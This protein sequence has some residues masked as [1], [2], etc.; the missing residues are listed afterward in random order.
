MVTPAYLAD[1]RSQ[2]GSRL[3]A[4]EE[5]PGTFSSVK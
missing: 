1:H 3:K 5:R 2:A 4:G